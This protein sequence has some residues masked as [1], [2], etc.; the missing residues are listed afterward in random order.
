MVG[1]GAL[2]PVYAVVRHGPSNKTNPGQPL[3][4]ENQEAGYILR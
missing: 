3:P 1:T 4:D 2:E